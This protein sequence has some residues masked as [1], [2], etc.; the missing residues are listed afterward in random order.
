M[1][2][3][4]WFR[5]QIEAILNSAR[6]RDCGKVQIKHII[7][8]TIANGFILAHWHN[9]SAHLI[10]CLTTSTRRICEV[11]HLRDCKVVVLLSTMQHCKVV[12]LLS[13]MQHCKVVALLS[14]M[15]HCKVVVLLSA[16]QHCKV[17]V[18]LS[19][20]QHGI[21]PI[22]INTVW[23]LLRRLDLRSPCLPKFTTDT[24]AVL[25][26]HSLHSLGGININPVQLA[27]AEKHS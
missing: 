13:T 7:M 19:T 17:L 16:M 14:T 8:A 6:Q 1:Y 9:L 23:Q 26:W 12:V 21:L 25:Q 2:L 18:L 24:T 22:E 20:M 10:A 27:K 4:D 15:Q 11:V 5:L 3:V